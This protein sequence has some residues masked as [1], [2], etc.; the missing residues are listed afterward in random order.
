[1]RERLDTLLLATNPK[2]LSLLLDTFQKRENEY[3]ITTAQSFEVLLEKL[4]SGKWDLVICESSGWLNLEKEHSSL[5]E[6]LKRENT[7]IIPIADNTQ[8]NSVEGLLSLVPGNIFLISEKTI[9]YLPEFIIKK[10]DLF[11]FCDQLRS[12]YAESGI[13]EKSCDRN[14]ADIL[15]SSEQRYQILF[16]ST[17]DIIIVHDLN[18]KIVEANLTACKTLG[19]KYDELL[20]HDYHQIDAPEKKGNLLEK[21]SRIQQFED[22][23]FISI[24]I[25]KTGVEIPVSLKTRQIDLNSQKVILTIARDISLAVI[26]EKERER[27]EMELRQAQKMEPIGRLA[28]GVAHDF[29]NALSVIMGQTEMLRS[30]LKE[31]DD[32]VKDFSLIIKAG[33]K[34]A[35]L[36][37][38]LLAI[39]R[40]QVLNPEPFYINEVILDTVNLLENLLRKDV[41][42]ETFLNPSAGKVLA[43]KSQ[44][45]QVIMNL[46]VNARD[47]IQSE[48]RIYIKTDNTDVD[49]EFVKNHPEFKP[50]KYVVISVSDNGCGMDRKTLN[51]IFEPFY[52]TKD[53]GKGTG[54]GLST[55]Y[56]IVK[57]HRGNIIVDSE[58]GKGSNFKIYLPHSAQAF[59]IAEADEEIQ[60]IVKGN[61][62]KIL[63]FESDGDFMK[64]IINVLKQYGYD[65]YGTTGLEDLIAY[66]VAHRGKIDLLLT[67]I[68]MKEING[69]ELYYRL[70]KDNS[71]LKVI[72]MSGLNELSIA[73]RKEIPVYFNFIQKPFSVSSLTTK[74]RQ[75]LTSR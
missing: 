41:K 15:I 39:S 44:I 33:E 31:R 38:K 7:L 71:E 17:S 62:E 57:Q 11:R 73:S 50:G 48:G 40:K 49:E 43:D 20:D 58:P 10:L 70:L 34:A 36:T 60:D 56:G 30:K 45:D 51:R 69:D 12:I 29:N 32:L 46:V 65:P 35:D 55:V 8:L 2:Q 1:M 53:P 4:T 9:P 27:L 24:Y 25:S 68:F 47:A 16:D 14:I 59:S 5:L 75:V 6:R 72:F 64:R 61:G 23:R 42:L 52:T 19:Y 22:Y 67:D 13:I 54:L 74:I 18:G 26:S 28:G 37:K 21:I 3:S 63:V 66:S